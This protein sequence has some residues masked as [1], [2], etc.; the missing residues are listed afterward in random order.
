MIFQHPFCRKTAKK[1][2]RGPFGET[3]FSEKKSR[4][5]EKIERGTLCDGDCPQFSMQK[6]VQGLTWHPNMLKVKDLSEIK[7]QKAEDAAREERAQETTV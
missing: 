2:K 5:A 3:I 1:L 6:L 7:R 4:S